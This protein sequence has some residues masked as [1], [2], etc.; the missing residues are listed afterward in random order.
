MTLEEAKKII[1]S[2]GHKVK[3]SQP[4]YEAVQGDMNCDEFIDLVT[5]GAQLDQYGIDFISNLY[6]EGYTVN[7]AKEE[8]N[9]YISKDASIDELYSAVPSTMSKQQL[10]EW[11]DK[12]EAIKSQDNEQS[13]IIE[14]DLSDIKDYI[15]QQLSEGKITDQIE[16]LEE[17]GESIEEIEDYFDTLA[18][19]HDSA[20]R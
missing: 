10:Q 12:Y 15:K 17:G 7:E 5:E 6:A 9:R 1:A 14:E 11:L 16:E 2:C 20:K 19:E 3:K 8:Y 13:K 18:D 4:V